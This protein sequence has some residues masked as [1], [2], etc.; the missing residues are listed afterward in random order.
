MLHIWPLTTDAMFFFLFFSSWTKVS[1]TADIILNP[2]DTLMTLISFTHFKSI[3][4][5]ISVPV[6]TPSSITIP[7]SPLLSHTNDV[8]SNAAKICR[9]GLFVNETKWDPE[10]ASGI[11]L[12]HTL[13]ETPSNTT[14][15]TNRRNHVTFLPHGT[16]Q[17]M[18]FSCSIEYVTRCVSHRYV[19][20][21]CQH[22]I[23]YVR[24]I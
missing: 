7:I 22:C 4:F 18:C 24:C 12:F 10:K 5:V 6:W 9:Y 23:V 8:K 21:P 3:V 1:F 15:R 19:F 17:Y 14:K 11:D 16:V 2:M 20:S 13:Y